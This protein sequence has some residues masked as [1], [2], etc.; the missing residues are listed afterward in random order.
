MSHDDPGAALDA[1]IELVAATRSAQAAGALLDLTGLDLEVERVCRAL[2]ESPGEQRH[3]H[4][5][6]LEALAASI[7]ALTTD[8][9]EAHS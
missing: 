8:L 7:D 1:L 6:K 5:A 3:V 9:K 4:L 2:T